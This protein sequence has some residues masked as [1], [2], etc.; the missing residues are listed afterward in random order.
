[1]MP[2]LDEV[3]VTLVPGKLKKH[4]GAGPLGQSEGLIIEFGLAYMF[5]CFNNQNV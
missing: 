3:E 1:M 2:L 5:F 4:P